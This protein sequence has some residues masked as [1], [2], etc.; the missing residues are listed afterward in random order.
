MGQVLLP[1]AAHLATYHGKYLASFRDV[2]V[3][4]FDQIVLPEILSTPD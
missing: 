2:Q 4:G 1:N 3:N